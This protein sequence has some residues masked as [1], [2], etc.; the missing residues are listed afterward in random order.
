MKN[1]KK[2]IVFIL[3]ALLVLGCTAKKDLESQ[4]SI[5]TPTETH[6][7][8][9]KTSDE[10]VNEKTSGDVQENQVQNETQEEQELTELIN[11]INEIESMLNELQELENLNFDV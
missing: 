11:D 9:T 10:P 7:S 5:Q 8:T 1:V 2:I 6:T 4:Q 3:M